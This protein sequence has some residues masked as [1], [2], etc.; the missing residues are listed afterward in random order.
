MAVD[1]GTDLSESADLR[2]SRLLPGKIYIGD[3][4][5]ETGVYDLTVKFYNRQGMVICS[6]TIHG[7][8]VFENDFNLVEVFSLN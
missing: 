7:F 6:K 3:F 8:Q 5:I 4:E 2:C 1:V